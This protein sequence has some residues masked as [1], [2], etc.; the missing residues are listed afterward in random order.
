MCCDGEGTAVPVAAGLTTHCSRIEPLACQQV[1]YDVVAVTLYVFPTRPLH[2]RYVAVT[3]PLQVQYDV[4]VY[5]YVFYMF[6]TEI[7]TYLHIRWYYG[8]SLPY[9]SNVWSMLELLNILPFFISLSLRT[10]FSTNPQRQRFSTFVNR[11]QELGDIAEQYQTV[12]MLDSISIL[13]SFIKVRYNS[14]RGLCTR[15]L[16]T[17]HIPPWCRFQGASQPLRSR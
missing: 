14:V 5:A 15:L 3:W 6:I 4:V 13:I 11:Y 2:F 12:F 9:F 1:Q 8:T 7:G 16:M 17:L 10:S